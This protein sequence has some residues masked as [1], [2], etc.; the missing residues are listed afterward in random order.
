MLNFVFSINFFIKAK[1]LFFQMKNRIIQVKLWMMMKDVVSPCPL[2]YSI[3]KKISVVLI[4][5]IENLESEKK[6][7]CEILCFCKKYFSE[8][9]WIRK[10]FLWEYGNFLVKKI[11]LIFSWEIWF[12]KYFV[13]RDLVFSSQRI[14]LD[15]GGILFWIPNIFTR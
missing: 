9:F 5:L 14:F 15:N 6:N 12:S 8:F 3:E 13:L 7:N 4:F 1:H 2:K 10:I 11:N